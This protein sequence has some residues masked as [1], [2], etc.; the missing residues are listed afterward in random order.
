[1]NEGVLSFPSS[2]LVSFCF[3]FSFF[4]FFPPSKY[5]FDLIKIFF[6]YCNLPNEVGND[7]N[8][9]EEAKHVHFLVTH[10]VSHSP[11]LLLL[12]LFYSSLSL[13]SYSPLCFTGERIAY[14]EYVEE[15]KKREWIQ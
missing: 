9:R 7:K 13:T 6:M 5:I 3:Y 1:M 2:V 4:L 15:E 14:A 11:S 8:R 10:E 12:L